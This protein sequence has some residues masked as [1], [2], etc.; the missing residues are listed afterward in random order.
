[1]LVVSLTMLCA[2]V[3][4]FVREKKNPFEEKGKEKRAFVFVSC[5]TTVFLVAHVITAFESFGVSS[6]LT[7]LFSAVAFAGSYVFYYYRE[8]ITE[9]WFSVFAI[10]AVLGWILFVIRLF[11]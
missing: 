8:K 3:I 11:V 7:G 1:M 5:A 6:V 10:V 9:K 2:F 4:S